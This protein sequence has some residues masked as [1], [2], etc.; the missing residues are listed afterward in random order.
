MVRADTDPVA[1]A[2]RVQQLSSTPLA[3][4]PALST[5]LPSLAVVRSQ[6]RSNW[7]ERTFC[8]GI[9]SPGNHQ[10]RGRDWIEAALIAG[11]SHGLHF[12][13]ALFCTA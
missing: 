7:N 10:N 11:R 4:G 8:G 2:A 3:Y 12:L 9:I 5:E 1:A 13:I 6:S